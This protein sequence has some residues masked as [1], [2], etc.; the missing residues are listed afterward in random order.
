M[1]S[2][3][4][5]YCL[6]GGIYVAQVYVA[7]EGEPASQGEYV[8]E[9]EAQR[10]HGREVGG[11]GLQEVVV[12]VEREADATLGIVVVVEGVVVSVREEPDVVA[13]E[14]VLGE[15]LRDELAEKRPGVDVVVLVLDS[16]LEV[17]PFPP[18]VGQVDEFLVRPV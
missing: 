9:V 17:Y 12:G 11:T 15:F 14:H 1:D 13:H 7:D 10:E 5:V 18:D 16:G 4:E 3:L 2:S 6:G 8:L